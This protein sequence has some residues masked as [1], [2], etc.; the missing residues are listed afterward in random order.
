MFSGGIIKVHKLGFG[1]SSTIWL[2]RK[3]SGQLVT[4]KVM[5]AHLSTKPTN[6]IAEV[7]IPL[8][9]SQYTSKDGDSIKAELK[10]WMIIS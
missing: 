5:G 10:P 4:L 3:A 2:A 9:H 7:A 6:T 1:G 8:R